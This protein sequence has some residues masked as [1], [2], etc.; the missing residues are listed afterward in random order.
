M[1]SRINPIKAVENN[2]KQ[3]QKKFRLVPLDAEKMPAECKDILKKIPGDALKGRHAPVNV[4]GT[5][6]YNPGTLVQFLDY[7]VTSK[8]KLCL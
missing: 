6:I 4:L 3:I 1:N 5:L 2:G 8:R 7:W